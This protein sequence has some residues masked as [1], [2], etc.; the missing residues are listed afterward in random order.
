[1]PVFQALAVFVKNILQN[2]KS[3]LTDT[4]FVAFFVFSTVSNLCKRIFWR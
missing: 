1:M 2:K 4:F 3:I